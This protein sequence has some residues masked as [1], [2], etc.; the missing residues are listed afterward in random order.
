[1]EMADKIILVEKKEVH[2]SNANNVYNMLIYLLGTVRNISK[3]KQNYDILVSINA[4][5]SI[6][7][8]FIEYATHTID[9]KDMNSQLLV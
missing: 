2:I 9:I 6:R 3:N 4:I 7:A 8:L 5:E 1:M